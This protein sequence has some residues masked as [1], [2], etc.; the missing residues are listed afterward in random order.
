MIDL[1]IG[2]SE[3]KISVRSADIEAKLLVLQV[4][5]SG[6]EYYLDVGK[7]V[8]FQNGDVSIREHGQTLHSHKLHWT[9]FNK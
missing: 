7:V 1:T 6:E 3:S 5:A 8:T 4:V 9:V 2:S